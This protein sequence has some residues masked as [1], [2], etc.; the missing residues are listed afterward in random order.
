MYVVLSIL[1]GRGRPA[2]QIPRDQIEFLMNQGHTVKRMARMLGCSSSFLYKRS[3]DLGV[4]VRSRMSA[5]DDGELET[6]IRRLHSHYPNSG[7]EMMRALLLAEGMRVSR[8]RVREMLVCI[9]P[10]AAARRWSSTVSRRV[11][12]VPHPNSLWH[13]DGNMRLIRWGFVVHGAIDGYSRLIT[14]LNCN[15]DNC[16]STVLSQFVHATCLYGLP[17]RVRSDHGGENLQVA[18]FMNLMQGIQRHSHITG[19]S[20]HN[21]RIERLWRDVFL[22]VLQSFYS[23][24][25]SLEDSE[26]LIPGND[27]HNVSLSLVFLPEIQSRLQHFKEAWNHHALRTEHNK[28][29]TQ[30]WTEGMLSRG[31]TKSTA[32]N[33][34]FGDDPYRPEHFYNRLAEHGIES[35]PTAEDEDIPAVTVERPR[36]T[37]SPQQIEIFSRAI[38]HVPDLKVR[39]QLCCEEVANVLANQRI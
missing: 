13:I 6:V 39:F 14:Y 36:I 16:A 26:L 1:G 8:I 20:V 30:I 25:Y 29:P 23:T 33:N 35:L 7:S 3:K 10:S 17:S 22:H 18:L 19:E 11:Y 9:N 12:N 5:V 28:T 38:E 24:F 34:V 32:M 31:Q 4:P 37:L 15:T 27:V 2:I 21:Q